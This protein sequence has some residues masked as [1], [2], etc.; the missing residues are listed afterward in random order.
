MHRYQGAEMQMSTARACSSMC[1]HTETEASALPLRLVKQSGAKLT[2]V[3]ALP[4]ASARSSE[5]PQLV[6]GLAFGR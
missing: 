1:T 5:S 2:K 6:C 4:D 3:G